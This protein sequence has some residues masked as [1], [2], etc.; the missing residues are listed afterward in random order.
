MK[1]WFDVHRRPTGDDISMAAIVLGFVSLL[2]VAVLLATHH[3]GTGA[4]LASAI[5]QMPASRH[6]TG[7]YPQS[8]ALGASNGR[9][10]PDHGC[11]P[12]AIDA[13]VITPSPG[14]PGNLSGTICTPGWTSEAKALDGELTTV[15]TQS[16]AA[17][18]VHT[19]ATLNW[20]IP[21]N[22]GGSNDVSNLF[23]LPVA[24][25]NAKQAVD[26]TVNKAVCAGTTTLTAA[27]NA[28]ATNWTTAT[29]TLGLGG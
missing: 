8:C 22:L 19:Q 27:Q 1:G 15:M 29:Q 5:R 21:L 2:V 24:D 17:Y 23:V 16:V 4:G 11:T 25:A 3:G 20:L 9:G 6:V 7:V 12:G 10:V 28:M 26:A 14:N 18:G 13:E